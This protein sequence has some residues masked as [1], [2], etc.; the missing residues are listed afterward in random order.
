MRT[1]LCVLALATACGG[2]PV[3]QNAPRP[4]PAVVAAAAAATATAVTLADPQAA[5]RKAEQKGGQPEGRVVGGD[6]SMPPGVL[7]RLDAIPADAG[8]DAGAPAVD[9]DAAPR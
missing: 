8:V 9:A 7:D 1:I 3:L 5:A 2:G 6:R 4:D